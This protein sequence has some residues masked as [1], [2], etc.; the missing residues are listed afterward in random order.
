MFSVPTEQQKNAAEA[1]LVGLDNNM[2]LICF[3][4]IIW[5]LSWCN[6]HF[7]LVDAFSVN[8]LACGA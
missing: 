2:W 3:L 8:M 6:F 5:R 4:I 7:G 1:R